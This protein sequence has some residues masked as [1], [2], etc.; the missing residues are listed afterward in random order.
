MTPWRVHD[1]PRPQRVTVTRAVYND[2]VPGM[3]TRPTIPRPVGATPIR[4]RLGHVIC[5]VTFLATSLGT[6][7]AIRLVGERKERSVCVLRYANA[8]ESA[9]Q[10][11]LRG[12]ITRSGV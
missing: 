11:C 6:I 12:Q 4:L 1:R 10:R 5:V 3:S 9:L 7:G 2:S 8:E